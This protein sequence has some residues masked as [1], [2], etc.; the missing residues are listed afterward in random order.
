MEGLDGI[1][2]A[3][4]LRA[5]G[6]NGPLVFVTV[7]REWALDAFELDACDYL[8]K[9]LNGARF[10]RTMDRA[11]ARLAGAGQGG[12]QSLLVRSGKGCEVVPLA[13]ILYCE[14]QGRVCYLHKTD[15]SVTGYP[16]K[17]SRLARQLDARFF[18]CRR[19]YLVNLDHVLGYGGGRLSLPFW[20]GAGLQLTLL[21]GANRVLLRAERA[22]AALAAAL[23]MYI[24]HLAFGLAGSLETL[25]FPCLAGG[26]ALCGLLLA[27]SAAAL[28]LG[29]GCC[30][31]AVRALG[32]APGPRALPLLLTP[33]L[34]FYLAQTYVMQTAYTEAVYSEDT[35]FLW[36]QAGR[37]TGLLLLQ[38]L[39]LGAL[40]CTLAAWRGVCRVFESEAALRAERQA[41]AAQKEYLAEARARYERTRALRHDWQNHL[42]VLDGLLAGGRVKQ[43]REYLQ[44]L[45]SSVAALSP[46]Y[47]TGSPA[48]DI[49]LCEKLGPAKA[50]GITAE[51]SL[52]LPKGCGVDETDLAVLFANALDN[53]LAA[54]RAAAGERRIRI[55]GRRQGDFLALSFENTCAEGPLAPA[56][57]GLGNIKAVARRYHGTAL[58]EKAGACFRLDVLLNL[59]RPGINGPG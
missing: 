1:E 33:L 18:C 35:A 49:L 11:L 47:C 25:F 23:A 13:A 20:A 59:S 52:A 56:G 24:F 31:L 43:G 42:V 16:Q 5:A 54:C 14:V 44:K 58:A 36:A 4:R 46:L 28:A 50:E 51:V 9:P 55:T 2:T 27:A 53:A 38:A 37:H 30:R 17:I 45:K 15:G 7:L 10:A 39:G 12:T 32:P 34:F 22:G 26:P 29:A 19:S 6:M 3:R 40:F 21:Y 8:L 41:A 48:T 57:I